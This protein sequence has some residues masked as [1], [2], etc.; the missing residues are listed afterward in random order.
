MCTFNILG[1][2]QSA[3]TKLKL[4]VVNKYNT[5]CRIKEEEALILSEMISFVNYY[6]Y[7]VLQQLDKSIEGI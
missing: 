5:L 1:P 3:T 2:R 6:K 7:S 4:E